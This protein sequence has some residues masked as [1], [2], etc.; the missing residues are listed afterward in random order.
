[1][2]EYTPEDASQEI[3][4][5]YC[6]CGCGQQTKIVPYTS[7]RRGWVKGERMRFLHGHNIE[8]VD[9]ADR[10]WSKV[11]KSAGPDGCWLWTGFLDRKGYG[12]FHTTGKGKRAYAHRVAYELTFGPVEDGKEVC[13]SCD[14]PRCVNPSHLWIGTHADN[15]RDATVKDRHA[16]GER[17]GHAILTKADILAIR[18]EY[19]KGASRRDL[20]ARYKTCRANISLIVTGK[21]WKH[22]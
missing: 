16:R 7:K 13:H 10:F 1:M 17:N 12:D 22:V 5:G 18:D 20:S 9:F 4:Y 15:M 3:P 19:A 14:N 8:T 6:Q 11:D 21:R 2:S